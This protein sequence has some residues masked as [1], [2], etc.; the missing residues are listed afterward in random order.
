MAVHTPERRRGPRVSLA[1]GP[2]LTLTR[3]IRVRL[4]DI[5]AD[6]ALLAADERVPIGAKGRLR[7]ALG[8]EPFE[9]E[10]EVVR[11]DA[12]PNWPHLLG[13]AM[14][15]SERR[16]RESLEHFLRRAGG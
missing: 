2:G 8:A 3:R 11:A 1:S 15:T 5:S 10:V 14:I 7:L 16:H 12:S 9:T 13:V 6:G 4:V